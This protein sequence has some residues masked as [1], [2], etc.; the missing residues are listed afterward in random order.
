[1]IAPSCCKLPDFREKLTLP[2]LPLRDVPEHDERAV[3]PDIDL[4]ILPYLFL[5][6][7]QALH[8]LPDN[9]MG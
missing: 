1:M 7:R 3:K 9:T 6:N 4:A 8:A 2:L 5:V